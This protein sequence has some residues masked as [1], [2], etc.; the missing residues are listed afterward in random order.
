MGDITYWQEVAKRH[1]QLVTHF[2]ELTAHQ[3]KPISIGGVGAGR[4]MI[5]H[6]MGLW[7]PWMLGNDTTKLVVGLGENMP[8]TLLIGLPFQQSAQ[9]VID[10]GNGICHSAVFNTSWKLTHKRPTKK[11]VRML[12]AAIAAGHQNAFPATVAEKL[13]P[14]AKLAEQSAFHVVSDCV[15]AVAEASQII[16]PSPAK[17]IRW[18]WDFGERSQE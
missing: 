12:D 15:G 9:C 13:A 14:V 1:P 3:E 2:E 10:I 7:L 4:V 16:S 11:D 8:M 18:D 6:V 5:T 17:K